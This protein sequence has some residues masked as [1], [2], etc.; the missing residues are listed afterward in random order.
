MSTIK[1]GYE[2]MMND[3]K[4]R[5]CKSKASFEQHARRCKLMAAN[6]TPQFKRFYRE[7]SNNFTNIFNNISD[8]L[9]CLNDND[10]NGAVKIAKD[11]ENFYGN[12]LNSIRS[13]EIGEENNNHD[14]EEL[15]QISVI[16]NNCRYLAEAKAI[17]GIVEGWVDVL[18]EYSKHFG[19]YNDQP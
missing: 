15:Y 12:I 14:Q 16:L 3:L 7:L 5:L 6:G 4:D 2:V 19:S 9:K 17:Y 13:S 10:L 11:Q 8:I 1:L 18:N